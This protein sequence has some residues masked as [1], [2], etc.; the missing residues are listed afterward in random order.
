LKAFICVYQH[1]NATRKD[2]LLTAAAASRDGLS[3][4]FLTHYDDPDCFY[5]WG[6]DSSFFR[7]SRYSEIL[8][9]HRGVSADEMCALRFSPEIL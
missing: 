2:R 1:P 6:D 8:V 3:Q 7:P 9:R 5:D 4:E